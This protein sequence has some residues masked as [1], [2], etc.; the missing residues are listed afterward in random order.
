MARLSGVFA[1]M[2]G[3]ARRA[4]LWAIRA[5]FVL[6]IV[7]SFTV[8]VMP[9]PEAPEGL[10]WDKANHFGAFYIMTGL[11]AAARPG[12]SPWVM[13][14]GLWLFGGAIEV[15]QSIPFVHRDGDLM[16]WLADTLGILAVLAPLMVRPWWDWLGRAPR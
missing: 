16:D 5:G 7:T 9:G 1:R 8:S 14:L 3:P 12:R 13:A 6:A 4:A 10:P 2:P 15:V 11:G